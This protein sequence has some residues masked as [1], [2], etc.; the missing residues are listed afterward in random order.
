MLWRRVRLLNR[1]SAYNEARSTCNTTRRQNH[2][3]CSRDGDT[4][5][6]RVKGKT[7]KTAQ[8]AAGG[9]TKAQKTTVLINVECHFLP[10]LAGFVSWDT[11]DVDDVTYPARHA[12]LL[13]LTAVT[14]N[15]RCQGLISLYNVHVQS[16][17][18]NSLT[19]QSINNLSKRSSGLSHSTFTAQGNSR[20]QALRFGA[21]IP[22]KIFARYGDALSVFGLDPSTANA[23]K[24]IL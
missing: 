1:G 7:P 14:L 15:P 19:R 18:L 12:L 16:F 20:I 10:A 4:R 24:E 11:G 13:E 5:A 17:H 22:L 21:Q 2:G 23:F 6:G 3:K 9:G 8:G